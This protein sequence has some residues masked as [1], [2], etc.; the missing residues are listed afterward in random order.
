MDQDVVEEVATTAGGCSIEIVCDTDEGSPTTTKYHHQQSSSSSPS[1]K[2]QRSS[3]VVSK[4]NRCN[5]TGLIYMD[6]SGATTSCSASG[7]HEQ[8]VAAP[9]QLSKKN[10]MMSAVETITVDLDDDMHP[11]GDPNMK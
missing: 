8:S 6:A 9:G 1:K 5:G 2:Q 11:Q 3:T 10:K 4:C 7:E